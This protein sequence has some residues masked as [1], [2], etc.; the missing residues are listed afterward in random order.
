MS[1]R[2]SGYFYGVLFGLV[3]LV[4]GVVL[5]S[6]LDLT[7]ASLARINVPATNSPAI[8][9]PLDATH[10]P[11]LAHDVSPAVVSIT[12]MSRRPRQQSMSDLFGLDPF[13]GQGGGG[14]RNQSRRTVPQEVPV[15]GAGSGFVIDKAGF[16]LTN[17]H[18]V[19][20]ATSIS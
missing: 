20:D 4:A 11:N 17:S 8:T 6:R 14:G 19:E 10:V 15:Q 12:T 1:T 2:K 13:G 18:V 9:G 5:A 16:I 7:P 3:C